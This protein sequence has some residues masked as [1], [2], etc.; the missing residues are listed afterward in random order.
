[1]AQSYRSNK[2]QA[3]FWPDNPHRSELR[4]GS[5]A[6]VTH[7]RRNPVFMIINHQI[8]LTLKRENITIL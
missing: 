7:L 3:T 6:Q 1:M 4:R 8:Q 5:L 2:D